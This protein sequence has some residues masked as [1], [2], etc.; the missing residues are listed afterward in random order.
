[1]YLRTSFWSST[2]VR[3][4]QTDSMASI[5]K[6]LY[7][8]GSPQDVVS[9]C[10][11]HDLR[12]DM[13]CDDCEEFIC[14]K[15]VKTSHKDHRWGTISAA[16]SLLRKD[17]R[18]VLKP[19]ETKDIQ[20]LDEKI[21]DASKQIKENKRKC[22][23]EISK[24][25]KH[26][27]AILKD[28]DLIR[29]NIEKSLTSSLEFKESKV[30]RIR[31]TLKERKKKALR[32]IKDMKENNSDMSDLD[33]LKTYRELIKLSSSDDSDIDK[34]RYSLT[35]NAVKERQGV[36]KTL[37]GEVLDLQEITLKE[38]GS[39]QWGGNQIDDLVAINVDSCFL[40]NRKS[41][42]LERVNKSGRRELR[43]SLCVNSVFVTDKNKVYLTDKL[44]KCIAHLSPSDS[45]STI[46]RT[47]PLEPLGI[48]QTMDGDLLVTLIDNETERYFP[49]SHGRCLLRRMTTAGEIVH[50]YEYNED[51][52]K[53]LFTWPSR[54]AQNGITD[55]CV[56][57][58]IDKSKGELLILSFSGFL[59]SVYSGQ[60]QREAFNPTDVDCDPNSNI[61]VCDLYDSTIHLLNPDGKF[62]K[63]LLTKNQVTH[64]TAMSLRQST[65]WIGDFQGVVKVFQ[66]NA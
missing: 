27:D 26:Y 31:S 38:T 60:G 62:M 53:K 30:R 32:M 44:H 63:F 41:Q 37:I 65:L 19:I 46:F 23:R 13:T 16:T 14:S 43:F 57:N 9:I 22:E 52:K 45:I 21:Q 48:Y 6:E 66:Y 8:F 10:E 55:I 59:K 49:N 33:L 28:L 35:F 3:T 36:I 11:K 7:R 47:D 1:M 51:G 20:H 40:G 50:D 25:Q 61:I 54:V 24:L 17:L 39:F 42:S 29:D 5:E 4:E 56:I 34:C 12:I 2:T 58:R 15:C 64:P 18:S